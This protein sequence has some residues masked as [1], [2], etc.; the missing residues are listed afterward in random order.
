MN[1]ALDRP[2]Q[3]CLSTS[4][5]SNDAFIDITVELSGLDHVAEA[6]SVEGWP[7][8]ERTVDVVGRVSENAGS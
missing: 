5:K 8:V 3:R 1:R 2:T 6:P 7:I 4:S